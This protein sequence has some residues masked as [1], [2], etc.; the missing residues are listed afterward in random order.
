MTLTC[1]RRLRFNLNKGKGG[2]VGWESSKCNAQLVHRVPR[3][4]I[5]LLCCVKGVY[6]CVA[7]VLYTCMGEGVGT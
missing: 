3:C 4:A 2:K 1:G 7:H 5:V 6:K